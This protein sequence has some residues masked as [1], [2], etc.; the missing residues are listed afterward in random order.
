MSGNRSS[1]QSNRTGSGHQYIF[2]EHRER[3]RCMYRVPKRIENS[4]DLKRNMMIVTPYVRHGKR[5][6][7]GKCSR[8]VHADALG[9]SAQMSPACQTVAAAAADHVAFSADDLSRMEIADVRAN[10]YDLAHEL[11]S[12][13]K[14]Y[15]DSRS[16]PIV[17]L[18]D[19]KVSTANAGH[20]HTNQYVIDAEF[21]L[22]NIFEPQTSLALALYQCFHVRGRPLS[23]QR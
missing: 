4:G 6:V 20:Q 1:H 21:R 2:A 19:V 23:L 12:D 18:V 8:A 11:M 3:K 22:G 5:N 7:L 9:M 15:G 14:R 13:D 17:P 16:R 10:S